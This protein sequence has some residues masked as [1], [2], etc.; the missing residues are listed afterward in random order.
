MA[1]EVVGFGCGKDDQIALHMLAGQA[2]GARGPVALPDDA[3][4]VRG[5]FNAGGAENR[6]C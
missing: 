2:A 4:N 1:Q 6:E 3:V 5:T